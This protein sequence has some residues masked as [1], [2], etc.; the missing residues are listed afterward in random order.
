MDDRYRQ[1]LKE[2]AKRKEKEEEKALGPQW[3]IDEICFDKQLEFIRSEERHKTAVCSRR[4]G[5]TWACGAD[6]ID[7]ALSQEGIDVAYI[8]LSRRN[9]KRLIWR[10]LLY[11]ND[12]YNLEGHTDNQELSI[13][14]PNRSTIWVS[15]AKDEG[16]V[17]KLR[18]MGLYKVYIDECQSFRPYLK[19]LIEDV[20]EPSLLDHNGYLILIGTPGP[21]CAGVFYDATHDP[22]AWAHFKWTM[23]DNPHLERKSGVPVRELM[24]RQRERRGISASD[25]TYLREFLG[26][27]V[28]D[29]DSL[30]YKYSAEKN[31][32][33]NLPAGEWHHIFGIDIGHEDADAIAVLAFSKTSPEVY[34]VDEWIQNKLGVTELVDTIKLLKEKYN[35]IKMVM[36]AGGLGKKIQ[37]EIQ[38]RH[39]LPIEAAEKKRKL[40]FIELLNDDLRTGRFRA[41]KTSQLAE[42]YAL[43][44]WDKSN[45]EKRKVSNVFHSDIADAALYAWRESRHYA[46]REPEIAPR[47]GTDAYMDALEEKEAMEMERKKHKSYALGEFDLS[48]PLY[49][50]ENKEWWENE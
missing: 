6:L 21:I 7:T 3:K 50:M 49:D 9:A 25:P 35:P 44:Q 41:R 15:G 48:A 42:E 10:Q 27:W 22:K 24:K 46:Y 36:D 43:I 19:N 1:L 12:L 13:T 30:V 17:E 5:K 26:E 45:P 18:G 33:D 2:V 23:M 4:A 16:D 8:T 31:H 47:I 39:G 11:F 40:E 38:Q 14:F 29:S 20:L 32:F 28:Y 34:L 37:M